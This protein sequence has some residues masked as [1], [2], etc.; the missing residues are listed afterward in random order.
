MKSVP[1]NFEHEGQAYS[2]RASEKIPSGID[3][4]DFCLVMPKAEGEMTASR[5]EFKGFPTRHFTNETDPEG[6]DRRIVLIRPMEV[7]TFR[8]GRW[9]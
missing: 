3:A 5:V 4:F 8:W 7:V 2:L 1:M 9:T 6:P